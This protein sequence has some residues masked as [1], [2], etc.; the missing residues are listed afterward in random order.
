[1]SPEE[2]LQSNRLII[3]DTTLR[4]GEQE[5]GFPMRTD[6]KLKMARQLASLGVDVIEAGFP[7]ASDADAEAVRTVATPIKGPV[8]AA[9]AGCPGPTSSAR[10]G[11]SSLRRRSASTSSSPRRIC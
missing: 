6:E 3:F 2:R 11:R 4:D 7:I 9:L 5:P 10:P 1:M 8:M